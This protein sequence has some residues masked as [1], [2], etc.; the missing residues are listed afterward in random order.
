VLPIAV[1]S[2][3]A[4]AAGAVP[5]QRP[6][7]VALFSSDAVKIARDAATEWNRGPL[8]KDAAFD[9]PDRPTELQ[10]GYLWVNYLVGAHPSMTVWINLT[11]GQVI[12]PDRCLYFHS[13]EIR[14]FS[15]NIRRMTGA[16]PI[17]LDRLANGIGCD[18]LKP[19]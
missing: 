11:T 5:A 2:S 17:A 1:M 16:H 13:P 19:D 3:L 8:P 12:E 18:S 15:V 10:P 4:T 14:A 7:P 6:Q 9:I